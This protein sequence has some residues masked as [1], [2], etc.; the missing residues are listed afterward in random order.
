LR[1]IRVSDEAYDKLDRL[2]RK[3][4]DEIGRSV[5]FSEVVEGLL[6]K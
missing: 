4:E 2:K 1:D 5:T 3:K 6:E